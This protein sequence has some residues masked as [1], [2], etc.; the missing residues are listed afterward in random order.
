[1]RFDAGWDYDR[2]VAGE[3]QIMTYDFIAIPE[4]DVPQASDPIEKLDILPT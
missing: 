2:V 3:R 1:V 4:P